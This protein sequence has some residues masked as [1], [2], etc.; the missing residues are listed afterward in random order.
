M[1]FS[2]QIP[3][4]LRAGAKI[5][6]GAY[7]DPRSPW[8]M[9]QAITQLSQGAAYQADRVAIDRAATKVLTAF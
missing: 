3:T 7:G 6:S 9:S 5:S 4:R 1:R 8:A 2:M